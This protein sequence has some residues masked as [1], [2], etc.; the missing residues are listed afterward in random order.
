MARLSHAIE[1]AIQANSIDLMRELAERGVGISF[2]TRI[3][4]EWLL[5]AQVGSPLCRW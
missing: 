3:G 5:A 1:P 4:I 2:H